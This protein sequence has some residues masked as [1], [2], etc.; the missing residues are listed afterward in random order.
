MFFFR[1]FFKRRNFQVGKHK[2]LWT[3][4]DLPRLFS[5][6][7][8]CV[9]L[10]FHCVSQTRDFGAKSNNQKAY[11]SPV[12]LLRLRCLN[13]KLGN[14]YKIEGRVKIACS[15]GFEYSLCTKSWGERVGLKVA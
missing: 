10:S 13:T 3:M 12:S 4:N 15:P 6:Y 14:F 7:L 2:F 11:K 5:R 8:Y 9:Y 1:Y